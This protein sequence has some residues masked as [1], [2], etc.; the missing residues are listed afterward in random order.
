MIDRLVK[1]IE[2]VIP[3]IRSVISKFEDHDIVEEEDSVKL[4]H[5]PKIAPMAYAA[6]IYQGIDDE[7]ISL[8][9]ESN[10][11]L[12]PAP[13]KELLNAMNG[14][15]IFRFELFGIPNPGNPESKAINR[16]TVRPLDLG[17]GN[18][19]WINGYNLSSTMFHFGSGPFSFDENV[20][21]FLSDDNEILS[22]KKNGEIVGKWHWNQLDQFF[23]QEIERSEERYKDFEEMMSKRKPKKPWWKFWA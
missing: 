11:I 8:Y 18:R 23:E 15:R 13:Y 5:R 17:T 9:E 10:Q 4:G 22:I 7:T 3:S 20:G 6:H 16:S 12:I 21:Y 2:T 19:A 14:S 1:S